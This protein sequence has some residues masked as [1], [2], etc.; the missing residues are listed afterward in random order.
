[1]KHLVRH[2]ATMYDRQTIERLGLSE[3]VPRPKP[4]TTFRS[5]VNPT[6]KSKQTNGDS[7]FFRVVR[8]PTE[9]E[10]VRLIGMIAAN[11]TTTCMSNHFF[12]IG[13]EIR[14]Q[15]DGGSIG[16]DLTGEV[17]RDYMLLWDEKLLQKCKTLG[18][19]F[20]LQSRYVNDMIFIMRPIGKG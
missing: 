10:I 13:G 18:F 7:Q 19:L 5:F 9:K 12:T 14:I 8:H 1:M 16:S 2:I 11:A 17:A 20:D 15:E 6:K 3:V 4:R